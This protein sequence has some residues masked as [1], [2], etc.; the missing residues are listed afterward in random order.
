MIAIFGSGGCPVGFSGT[1]CPKESPAAIDAPRP[2]IAAAATEDRLA[3]PGVVGGSDVLG[4][5]A[6]ISRTTRWRLRLMVSFA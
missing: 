5:L 3:T 1:P 4:H 2:Q 6:V